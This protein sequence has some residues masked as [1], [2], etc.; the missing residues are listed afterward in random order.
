MSFTKEKFAES[1]KSIC[2]TGATSFLEMAWSIPK[3][4]LRP[5]CFRDAVNRLVPEKISIAKRSVHFLPWHLA[6]SFASKD[7][8]AFGRSVVAW[9]QAVLWLSKLCGLPQPGSAQTWAPLWHCPPGAASWQ[10]LCMLNGQQILCP[11]LV[12]KALPTNSLGTF[13]PRPFLLDFPLPLPLARGVLLGCAAAGLGC[14]SCLRLFA[15]FGLAFGAG[16]A[17]ALAAN[18]SK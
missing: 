1:V 7:A 18:G 3:E 4:S 17:G 12:S 15:L 5:S 11:S 14:S 16:L 2:T 9:L 6:D 8:G 13:G 10:P